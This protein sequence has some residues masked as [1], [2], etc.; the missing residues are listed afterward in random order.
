MPP[1]EF[2]VT[3]AVTTGRSRLKY[4]GFP[5]CEK[6][7]TIAKFFGLAW[8]CSQSVYAGMRLSPKSLSSLSSCRGGKT[9]RDASPVTEKRIPRRSLGVAQ[10]RNDG[11]NTVPW[12]A[13]AVERTC[14]GGSLGGMRSRL[15]RE[16]SLPWAGGGVGQGCRPRGS[17]LPKVFLDGHSPRCRG[18]HPRRTSKR[19]EKAVEIC[20]EACWS[21]GPRRAYKAGPREVAQVQTMLNHAYSVGSQEKG[22]KIQK[23][24]PVKTPCIRAPYSTQ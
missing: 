20:R 2:E 23:K 19:R 24:N 21:V 18:H 6:T 5:R 17:R 3:A 12:P 13:T 9:A 15:S 16:D 22:K 10:V 14:L 11:S 8:R 4:S 7:R 1:T